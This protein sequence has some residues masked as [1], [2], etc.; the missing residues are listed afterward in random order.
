[1]VGEPASDGGDGEVERRRA[2]SASQW[3]W[4]THAE[5]ALL[6]REDGGSNTLV[7]EGGTLLG[8]K[9]EEVGRGDVSGSPVMWSR[10][11]APCSTA[12]MGCSSTR[13]GG[14]SAR[15]RVCTLGP[16]AGLPLHSRRTRIGSLNMCSTFRQL[17][18]ASR[19][20][21][22]LPLLAACPA[23]PLPLFLGLIPCRIIPS[24]CTS[25]CPLPPA[26]TAAPLQH[27]SSS[28]SL[29]QFSL[30]PAVVEG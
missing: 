11:L 19:W 8:Q 20:Q 14:D 22:P 30:F 15:V 5:V 6:S 21:F 26:A 17:V 12:L 7:R 10:R 24:P 9:P 18:E 25:T 27:R 28:P 2:S 4:E 1:M 29:P 13:K 16:L 3:S 23:S